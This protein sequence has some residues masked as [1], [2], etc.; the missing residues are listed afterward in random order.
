MGATT[1]EELERWAAAMRAN[2]LDK[3]LRLVF[4]DLAE[5]NGHAWIAE[6]LRAGRIPLDP[7]DRDAIEMLKCCTFLPGSWDK[8][9][10]RNLPNR[11]GTLT[12]D[13]VDATNSSLTPRQYLLLWILCHRYRRQIVGPVVLGQA[14]ARNESYKALQAAD[15]QSPTYQPIPENDRAQEHFR[16]KRHVHKANKQAKEL[17]MPLFD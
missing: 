7:C 6:A 13:Y 12:H 4:S 10:V 3:E 9:F 1:K 15:V 11:V 2:P 17:D 5:E 8:R 14:K 16:K